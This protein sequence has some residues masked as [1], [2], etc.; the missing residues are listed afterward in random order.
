[1]SNSLGENTSR[2]EKEPNRGPWMNE[3]YNIFKMQKSIAGQIA[4]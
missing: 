4:Y 1:M 3:K 2:F